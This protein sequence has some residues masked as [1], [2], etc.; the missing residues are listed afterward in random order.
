LAGEQ[1]QRLSLPLTSGADPVWYDLDCRAHNGGKLIYATEVTS[2][3]T[4]ET[5]RRNFVQTLAKT[6]A[7]LSTG[8][9][10]FDRRMQLVLFNPALVDLTGLP[11]EFLSM[12]PNLLSFFDRLRDSHIMPEPKDYTSWRDRMSNMLAAANAGSFSESWTL[13]NGL[14][15]E[16][17]GRP[18]PDGAVAFLFK[19]VSAEVSLT[20]R[21]RADLELNQSVLDALDEAVVVFS[22]SGALITSNLGYCSLWQVDHESD[23][24]DVSIVDAMNDWMKIAGPDPLW[25]ELRDFVLKRQDR[26]TWNS[27]IT[28]KDGRHVQCSVSPIHKGATVIR[29]RDMAEPAIEGI[30]I[31]EH[32]GA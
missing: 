18:H 2:L 25:G 4:A 20:R 23:F 19:D 9:A 17:T 3:V 15:Y 12:R 8:L 7:Q 29:F 26:T 1:P 14:T 10:I 31:P 28:F 32:L 13:P 16:V 30:K 5:S 21:S 27:V 6:F 24:R 11:V 22:V